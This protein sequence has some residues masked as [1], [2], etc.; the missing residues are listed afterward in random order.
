MDAASIAA[1]L[2][3]LEQEAKENWEGEKKFWMKRVKRLADAAKKFPCDEKLQNNLA[4]VSGKVRVLA[5]ARGDAAISD[6]LRPFGASAA[7]IVGF[8]LLPNSDL[9]HKMK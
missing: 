8:I 2:E 4:R 9:Q 7:T 3:Q 1:E 5:E 6:E